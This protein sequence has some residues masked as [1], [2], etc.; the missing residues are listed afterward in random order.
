M[1][2][3]TLFG[4]GGHCFAM[5]DLIRSSVE[6]RPTLI[7][8]DAPTHATILDVPVQT[9]SNQKIGT[10]EMVVSIG[11]NLIRKK[12]IQQFHNLSFP[13]LVH[14]SVQRYP[15]VAI[16]EGTHILP[17]AVLDA[18]VTIGN[19]CIINFFYIR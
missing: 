5:V 1:K 15:S 14:H 8:D 11:N 7:L 4:A 10:T 17:G 13:S 6:F 3:I 18:S 12:L 2:D 16:G 19:H 9:Y